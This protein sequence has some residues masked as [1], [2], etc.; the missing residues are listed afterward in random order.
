M[1]LPREVL[2]GEF[3]MLCRACT[4][5]MFLLRP[6]PKMNRMFKYCLAEAAR[7][8]GITIVATAAMP[9]HHHTV[10]FDRYGR[11]I[12]FMAHFHK[13]LAKGGN[14]LRRRWENFW[15]NEPPCLV[16]LVDRADVIAKIVYTLTNPVTAG[17]VAQVR[18]WPGVVGWRQF[19]DG[20]PLEV[21]RPKA[22]FRRDGAMPATVTLAF[23]IPPELGDAA[24]VRRTVV[25]LV[26]AVEARCASQRARTGARVMGRRAVRA[27]S[28]HARPKRREPRR[29]LRP[30]VAAR[31]VWRRIEALQRSRAFLEAYRAAR[32]AMLAKQPFVFPRGTYWLARFA[33]VPV[34]A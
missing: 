4:Q 27:Q 13:M 11:I 2:P 10:L 28:P 24:E 21:A 7:R 29:G 30:R 19:V 17:L 1:S 33:A 20:T 22:F 34:A 25:G 23:E 14:A 6:G 8:F 18:Q 16:R 12:E 15:S 5:R 9:N 31:N 26:E 32:T 3:Y